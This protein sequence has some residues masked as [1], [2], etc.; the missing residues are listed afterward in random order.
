MPNAING[1]GDDKGYT[2]TIQAD[3]DSIQAFYESELGKIGYSLFAVGEG[4]EKDTVM[5]FFM[6]D[7]EL[8]SISI[9]PSGDLML[10]LIVK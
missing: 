5:L 7:A 10:V 1:D 2:F 6:K 8:I 3:A 4:K 9:I